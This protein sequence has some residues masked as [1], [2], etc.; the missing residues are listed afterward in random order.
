MENRIGVSDIS[1]LSSTLNSMIKDIE[2]FKNN[3]DQ[4]QN[5]TISTLG[6]SW[7]GKDADELSKTINTINNNLKTKADA[8]IN[9]TNIIQRYVSTVEEFNSSEQKIAR[10]LYGWKWWII[11]AQINERRINISDIYSYITQIEIN[12]NELQAS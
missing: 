11:M 2:I 8:I 9:S 6:T 4:V 12:K 10:N 5:N 3:V 7:V 1:M